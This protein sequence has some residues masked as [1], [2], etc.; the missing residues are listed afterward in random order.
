M[1]KF[2]VLLMLSFTLEQEGGYAYLSSSCIGNQ[3]R[4]LIKTPDPLCLC[5][6]QHRSKS[7]APPAAGWLTWQLMPSL[8][9]HSAPCSMAAWPRGQPTALGSAAQI[10]ALCDGSSVVLDDT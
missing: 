7:S 9:S 5:C 8:A 4:P 1:T 10:V 2:D 3:L 6:L